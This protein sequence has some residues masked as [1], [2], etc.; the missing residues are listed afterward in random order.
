MA[1]FATA[2]AAGAAGFAHAEWRE[3]V[4]QNEALRLFAAAVGIDVLRF[5][6]RRQRGESQRLGFAALENGRTMRAR[7]N[8]DF[9]GD[10]AQIMVAAAI[11]AFLFVENADAK[12]FFLDVIERLRD[13]ELV[14]LR[15]FLQ[16]RRLHFL[17]QGVDRFAARD[18]AFGVKRAFDAV[19]G[20]A[21]GDLENLLVHLEQ[22]H[23]AL[24]L[25]D[26]AP[27]APSECESFRAH[28]RARTRAP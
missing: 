23:L 13:R 1:D 8:A 19:A 16:D 10:R 12:R 25:A 24:R 7:Q 18:F 20:N 28:V 11:D 17:A 5:F 14:G 22:R 3:I 9:A 21:V 2:G 26:L 15:I 27:R 4:V 6:D